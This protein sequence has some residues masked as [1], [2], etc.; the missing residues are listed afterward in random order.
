LAWL[1]AP[2]GERLFS[3]ITRAVARRANAKALRR[4]AEQLASRP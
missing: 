1:K 3:P 4:L 2:T